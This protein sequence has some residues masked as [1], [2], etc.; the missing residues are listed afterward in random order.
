MGVAWCQFP[1]LRK[2]PLSVAPAQGTFVVDVIDRLGRSVPSRGL[3]I[4]AQKNLV[5]TGII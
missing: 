2:A 1:M 5:D 3:N 4:G